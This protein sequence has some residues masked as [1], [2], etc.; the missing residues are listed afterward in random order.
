VHTPLDCPADH[1]YV[2]AL[3]A[4]TGG[5]PVGL[6]FWTDAAL[7]A[8]H[9]TPSVV[10]GPGD[11]AQAHSLDEWVTVDQLHRAEEVYSALA[12]HLLRGSVR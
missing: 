7:L 11:I 5:E 6:Q 4:I 10:C 8:A 2:E 3:C 9:G 1:P 12:G